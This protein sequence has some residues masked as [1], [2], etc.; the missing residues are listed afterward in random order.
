MK[1][2]IVKFLYK[3]KDVDAKD[4]VSVTSKR[5][6]S[7]ETGKIVGAAPNEISRLQVDGKGEVQKSEE[8]SASS[9]NNVGDASWQKKPLILGLSLCLI[10]AITLI[11]GEYLE[12]SSFTFKNQERR[13]SSEWDSYPVDFRRLREDAQNNDGY[14]IKGTNFEIANRYGYRDYVQEKADGTR[15]AM[16][17]SLSNQFSISSWTVDCDEKWFKIGHIGGEQED[18]QKPE[19]GTQGFAVAATICKIPFTPHY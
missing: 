9:S 8:D 14:I 18:L 3:N 6:F 5:S 2:A 17:R 16:V 13:Y 4:I 19:I 12:D 1:A 15:W 11:I 10:V 7:K